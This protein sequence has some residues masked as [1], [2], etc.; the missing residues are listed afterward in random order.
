SYVQTAEALELALQV[1]TRPMDYWLEYTLEHTLHALRPHGDA[2]EAEGR[3]LVG[4]SQ[5]MRDY[6]ANYKLSTGPG[7]RALQP[8]KDAENP[9]LPER[10]REKA[11][12]TLAGIQ[13]GKAA[14]GQLVFTRVCSACHK[15]GDNGKDF[16]PKLDDIGAR[17]SAQEIVRHVLWPN[18]TIAK[19][20]ETVQVLTADGAIYTGFILRETDEALTLGVASQDGKGREEVILKEDIELRKEMKAS[21]MPE[22]L[23][24]TIAPSEFLD[25]LEYLRQQ[26]KLVIDEDGWIETGLSDVGEL[27]RQGKFV[28]LSRH[29]Q[30]LLGKNFSGNWTKFANLL[31]SAADPNNREFAF[32][33]PNENTA[34][35]AVVIRLP[36]AA[37]MRH[38]AIQNRRN[39]SFY[40][41]A[42]D[43]AVWVS[44]DGERW[45]RVW[46]AT[47][48][49]ADYAIDLPPGT[50][51]RFLKVGLDGEGILHLNQIVVYGQP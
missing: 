47:E 31:L 14:N 36:Q 51:G 32:H 11:M 50:R 30:L 45:Q 39:A 26:N 19:G 7:G 34:S 33:S 27:R 1:T 8:L 23:I 28:E 12:Q 17:Y 9:A 2:A 49:A 21:S 6:Y 15:I 48:P 20:Y 5:A 13:G 44:E 4:A 43:L 29:A 37:E 41:R 10:V 40:D 24:K 35:P 25:L 46:R 42:K 16:G 18:A 22:G 3:F 38:V